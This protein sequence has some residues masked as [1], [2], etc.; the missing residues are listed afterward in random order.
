MNRKYSMDGCRTTF[1]I[2]H[3]PLLV[4]IFL[5]LCPLMR[6]AWMISEPLLLDSSGV[7]SSH[8]GLPFF[9]R[10]CTAPLLSS[11]CCDFWHYHCWA[12]ERSEVSACIIHWIVPLTAVVVTSTAVCSAVLFGGFICFMRIL[13]GSCCW[14]AWRRPQGA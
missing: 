4:S 2:R 7:S 1:Q 5:F 12:Q 14:N 8:S 6:A 13:S 3:S 9:H 11:F 10:P